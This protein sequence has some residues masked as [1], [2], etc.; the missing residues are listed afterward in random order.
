MNG[1]A[2]P[3]VGDVVEIALPDGRYAYGRVLKDASVAIYDTV[4]D[5]PRQAPV[6]SRG[7]QFVVG[8]YQDV[9]KHLPVVAHDA[10]RDADDEWPPP[11]R[12]T[13]VLTGSNSIYHRGEMRPAASGEAG[14]L[15][16]AGVWDLGQ[17]VDRIVS[18]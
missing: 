2:K 5:L 15:E 10:S 3:R 11:F 14:D 6:G 7:F 4:S 1:V 18:A 17:I 13:D 9:L 12:V 8:V 16:P